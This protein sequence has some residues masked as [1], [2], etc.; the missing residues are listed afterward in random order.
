MTTSIVNDFAAIAA[1]MKAE[2]SNEELSVLLPDTL[3]EPN[4]GEYVAIFDELARKWATRRQTPGKRPG[5]GRRAYSRL[6]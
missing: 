5:P 2:A 4:E 6:P 1:A 3:P